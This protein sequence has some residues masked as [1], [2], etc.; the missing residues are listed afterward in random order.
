M[1]DLK[2]NFSAI[3]KDYKIREKYLPTLQ[4][5]L[6]TV[7]QTSPSILQ[8]DIY[9]QFPSEIKED[10]QHTLYQLDKAG[11]IKR[12]KEGRTYKLYAI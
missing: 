7:I 9:K 4:Q 6:F 8:Q 12:E 1:N 10:I 5:D 3:E 2:T 11:K